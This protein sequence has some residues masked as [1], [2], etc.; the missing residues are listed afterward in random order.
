M[1]GGDVALPQLRGRHQPCA[2][3]GARGARAD[4]P[5]RARRDPARQCRHHRRGRARS[6][7]SRASTA[8]ASRSWPRPSSASAPLDAGRIALGGR[9]SHRGARFGPHR[10]RPCPYPRGSAPH[11][12]LFGH[13]GRRQ[14]RGRAG[15]DAALRR[16]G[17]AEARRHRAPTPPSWSSVSTCGSAALRKPSARC[18]AA[19][20]R[21]WC[22]A[23]P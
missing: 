11:R 8:T 7:G 13:A 10:R 6:S 21:R 12:H 14:R 15:R 17:P 23:A 9:R 3:C 22:S 20:S 2:A 5:R 18:R 16:L 19:T 1:V 4:Q